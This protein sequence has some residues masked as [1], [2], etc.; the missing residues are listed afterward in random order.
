MFPSQYRAYLFVLTGVNVLMALALAWRMPES[1]RWL[2]ARERHD[3]ARRI[4][5]RMEARVKK[6]HV[7][8]EPD[9]TPYEVVAEE[10]PNWLAPFGKQYVVTTV[11]ILVVMVLGY[12]GIVYGFG[13]YAIL[14]LSESRGYSAGFV[15]ALTAWAGV[16]AAAYVLNA[17][18]GDRIERKTTVMVG[19]VVFRIHDRDHRETPA[20]PHPR[21]ADPVGQSR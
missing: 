11:F 1:P 3:Q 17:F 8:S 5:E 21:R 16:A 15:F 14:F 4:V 19:A 2:E 20:P 7:L 9:L 13:G 6:H 18:F 12:G 10:K